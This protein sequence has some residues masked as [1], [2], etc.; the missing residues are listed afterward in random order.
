MA[1]QWESRAKSNAD[2]AKRLAEIEDAAKTDLERVTA[3]RDR[4]ATEAATATTRAARLE[5]A[6]AKGVPVDLLPA[7]ADAETLAAA[8]DALIA[9]RGAASPPPFAGSADGGARTSTA[10]PLEVLIAEAKAAG[11]YTLAISL[12]NSKLTLGG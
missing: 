11:N 1:R 10:K 6:T 12:E 5:V 3:E 4:L 2:A 8:A 9:F 7:T